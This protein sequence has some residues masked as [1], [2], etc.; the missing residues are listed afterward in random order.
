MQAPADESTVFFGFGSGG[1][2]SATISPRHS[3]RKLGI[4]GGLGELRRGG[5][6]GGWETRKGGGSYRADFGYLLPRAG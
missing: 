4:V 1:G 3:E 2:R 5:E 6:G